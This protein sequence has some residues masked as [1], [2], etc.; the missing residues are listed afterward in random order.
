VEIPEEGVNDAETCRS[1][2]FAYVKAAFVDVMNQ[3]FN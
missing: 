2:V 1:N 3:H